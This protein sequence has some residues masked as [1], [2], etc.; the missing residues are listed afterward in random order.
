[1]ASAVAL[2]LI[3]LTTA[4]AVYQLA[5]F[6]TEARSALQE[7]A[8]S[9]QKPV[10]TIAGVKAGNSWVA[11]TLA[12]NGPGEAVVESLCLYKYGVNDTLV[13]LKCAPVKRRV[14]PGSVLTVNVT[15]VDPPLLACSPSH[16][17]FP[18]ILPW[19]VGVCEASCRSCRR[20]PLSPRR[21]HPVYHDN[22]PVS[23]PLLA[24]ERAPRLF[25]VLGSSIQARTSSSVT[26]S[27]ILSAAYS[28]SLSFIV[29]PHP[30]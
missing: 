28:V 10:F 5:R 3:V 2:I 25:E 9:V 7:Y 13:G 29:A 20:L 1:M 16:P 27:L 12:N 22:V 6:Y 30:S 14:A 26:L 19:R 11:L 4:I 21:P 18:V 23:A 8:A 17:V 15:G 24:A